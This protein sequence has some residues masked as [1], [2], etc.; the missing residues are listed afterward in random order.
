MVNIER[1]KFIWQMVVAVALTALGVVAPW[2]FPGVPRLVAVL[3]F[4]GVI[5][6]VI[7]ATVVGY[8]L[9]STKEERTNGRNRGTCLAQKNSRYKRGVVGFIVLYGV[10]W[11]AVGGY[12]FYAFST[13]PE[14]QMGPSNQEVTAVKAELSH[15]KPRRMVLECTDADAD[16]NRGMGCIPLINTF[17]YMFIG[18][19]HTMDDPENV[20]ML[21]FKHAEGVKG[22][23]LSPNDETTRAIKKA[24]E[25]NTKLTVKLVGRPYRG[26]TSQRIFLLVGSPP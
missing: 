25:G 16:R 17:H 20:I 21:P 6:V 26:N 10:M 18:W 2:V 7:I 8:L 15:L 1:H 12:M 22:L 9:Q 19:P 5:A 11:I 3:V 13:A 14:Y 4:S 23:E 24:I